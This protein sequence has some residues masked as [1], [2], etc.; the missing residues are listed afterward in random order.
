M[1]PDM[2]FHILRLEALKQAQPEQPGAALKSVMKRVG[3][4]ELTL[5][6]HSRWSMAEAVSAMK[7]MGAARH[8]GKIV[9]AN[10]PMEAGQLRED[11]T[12]LVTGCLG[13]IGTTDENRMDADG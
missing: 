1:R 13:G 9:L 5:L 7:L 2:G 12:Y 8:I 11:R 10:S 3:T 6:V 4:G